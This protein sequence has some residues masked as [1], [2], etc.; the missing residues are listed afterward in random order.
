MTVS[1]PFIVD[2]GPEGQLVELPALQRLCGDGGAHPGVG[3]TYIH[4]PRLAPDAGSG[5]RRRWSDVVLEGHLRRAIQRLNP[6]LPTPAVQ[7]VIEEVKTTASPSVIEDHRGFHRLLLSGVPVSYRDAAGAERHAHAWIVDFED[8]SKNEFVAVNQ[9][10]IIVGDHNR[11]PDLI[12][13]VNGLP[14]GEIEAKAPGLEKPSEEAVNQIAHYRH[15]I[16]P[17]YRFIEIVGV[18]DLMKAVVGTISTPAEHFAEWKTMSEDPAQQARPQL[19]LMIEG[20]FQTGR[21]LELI[22]DFVLFETDGAKTWK[23]MAKYHQVHAVNAAI[24]SA[25]G[26]MTSDHRGGLIWHTQG[27]GKSYTMVFFVNKLRRD[28]RFDNPTV[29]AVTDRTDLDNQLADTFT[30]THLAPQCQQADEIRRTPNTPVDAKTL[31]ELLR[32]PAGGIVFTTIQKFRAPRGE[33]MP[34]LSERSNV[35]VMADE[36][37]RSQY[38]TFAENITL[39]LPNATRIGFTGTPIEKGDR[40]TRIVFGDYVSVYR[41]RQAQ[42]DQATVPIFYESRQIGLTIADEKALELVEDVLE[43]EEQAAAQQLVTSWAKL[44]KVVGAPD[45]LAKLADDLAAHYHARC[46]VLKGKALVVAYSR[47]VAA[48]LTELLRERLGSGTVDCVISAQATDDPEISRFRR[49]KPQLR[50]LAKRFRNPDDHLRVVVVKDMWL[51]GFDAPVLHT[52]YI[53][54]PMRDHGLLQAIARVNRVFEN[55]PGGMVVDYIGI[56]EDLRASLRAYDDADLDD[57]VVPAAKAVARL[58]EKYEVI[59]DLLHPMGYRQGEL[60]LVSDKGKLFVDAYNYILDT[61]ERAQSF[62]DAQLAL[63]TWHALGRT[64][65]AALELRDEVGFFGRL[66][67]EVRKITTPAVQASKEAEQV[68]RQFMSDGLAAGDVVDVFALADKD[69]PE[70]S[71][72]SD[73]FLDS[74]AVKAG[75]ENIQRRLLQKLLD[76]ELRA[77]RRVN[78]LQ[79]KRF[80]DEVEAV[81]RRYEQRQLTSAEVVER[82]IEIAKRLRDSAHRHGELGLTEEEAAFYDALAGGVEHVKADPALRDLAHELVESIRKDLSVD[83]MDREATEAKVR[84]KIKRLLRRNRD[85]LPELLETGSSSTG[86]DP[87]G[88]DRSVSHFT[89][90]VLDQ[91][92]AMYRY[93]PEVGD[94]L[95]DET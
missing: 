85:K 62:L 30:A 61:D 56:G 66:A 65:P 8:V 72:L 55:K 70:I 32:V 68:V 37:H 47:R 69:R 54:K 9:L 40:S 38:D 76:D 50:E 90:L 57:P 33:D 79:A 23:V 48:Q 93:W 71:V 6:D 67:A 15:T 10:T 34:V 17:L 52:L 87:T 18:T 84:T 80:S 42:E 44:E 49:S 88:R 89:Q 29:V 11:R 36:A 45:R 21:F 13:Y 43:D 73:E 25:A 94:R 58:W 77:R 1:D 63:N 27:A 22:R 26:A 41:M 7:R 86:G 75:Q 91:A 53:D 81:L 28:E 5:E 74:I 83:W 51:T 2:S 24:E 60:Y 4:G 46:E 16:P 3:W 82:L 95:F 39:A 59:C 14:L 64:Q 92:K 78:N 19:D 20:V 31:Y 12:L 35:I